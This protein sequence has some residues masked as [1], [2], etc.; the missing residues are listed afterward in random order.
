MTYIHIHN[1]TLIDGNGGDPIPN[2]NVL[3]HNNRI[4]EVGTTISSDA[5][6]ITHIDAQ[7]GYILPGLIDTHVHM[8]FEIAPLPLR[9]STPFSL[10]FFSGVEKKNDRKSSNARLQPKLRHHSVNIKVKCPK[11]RDKNTRNLREHARDQTVKQ[12]SRCRLQC[13]CQQNQNA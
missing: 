13:A 12:Y 6:D 5:E 10:N 3:I 1:G 9:V 7:G 8:M 4:V 2:A 11:R